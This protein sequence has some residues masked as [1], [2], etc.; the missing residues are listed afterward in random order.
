MD[1]TSAVHEINDT[2]GEQLT[3]ARRY[4]VD[5]EKKKPRPVITLALVGFAWSVM[6]FAAGVVYD[7]GGVA[8]EIQEHGT[9]LDAAL[10][11][12]A[13]IE[14]AQRESDLGQRT[15]A[16]GVESLEKQLAD[17]RKDVATLES[18]MMYRLQMEAAIRQLHPSTNWP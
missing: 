17:T 14:S 6:I 15:L 18:Q 13:A 5:G 10:Q 4:A 1:E 16:A 8:K 7:A 9:K 2:L 3:E 12:L 11:K